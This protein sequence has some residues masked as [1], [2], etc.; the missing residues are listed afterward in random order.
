[1]LEGAMS[2]VSQAL[3]IATEKTLNGATWA[4]SRVLRQPIDP[5][6][7]VLRENGGNQ[8]PVIAVYVEAATFDI[9]GRAT[10]GNKGQLDLKV[11]VYIAPGVTKIDD[12]TYDFVMDTTSAGLTLDI[13]GR[14][15]DA[16]LHTSLS[17]WLEIWRKIVISVSKKIEKYALIQIETG[18]RVPALEIL[19]SVHTIPDPD[20]GVAVDGM[21]A[22]RM[23]DAQLR[24]EGADGIKLADLF[25]SLIETPAGLQPYQTF[26]NNAG[27]TAADFASTGLAPVPGSTDPTTGGMPILEDVTITVTG[28]GTEPL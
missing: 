24:T 15:V 12:G 8:I 17:A 21:I 7:E 18:V 5:I 25:K 6:A 14:Q 2:L 23:I 27:L 10:Q 13:M 11:F 16:A 28:T 9:E 19:Y 1:M 4:G 3:V 22:W 20:F 26:V